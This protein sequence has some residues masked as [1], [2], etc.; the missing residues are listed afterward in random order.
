MCDRCSRE[1]YF[2]AVGILAAGKYVCEESITLLSNLFGTPIDV[3]REDVKK[4]R[5]AYGQA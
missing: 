4:S 3:V 1:K 5:K 2:E